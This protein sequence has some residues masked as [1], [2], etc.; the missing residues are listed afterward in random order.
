MRHPHA[1][2]CVEPGDRFQSDTRRI[3]KALEVLEIDEDECG[4]QKGAPWQA[5]SLLRCR[6]FGNLQR[7]QSCWV[8]PALASSEPCFFFLKFVM[9]LVLELEGGRV[10]AGLCCLSS[11]GCLLAK[12]DGPTF[13]KHCICW[14]LWWWPGPRHKPAAG[15]WDEI[16]HPTQQGS[17]QPAS[18]QL[19]SW[20][21]GLNNVFC[22]L[23]IYP[24]S[25]YFFSVLLLF[26][27]FCFASF[28]KDE[29][30]DCR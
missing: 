24:K 11:S 2:A 27:F 6:W 18:E 23:Q 8:C 4:E 20:K 14:D 5:L 15:E 3:P 21:L 10:P 9:C 17:L 13:A 19:N 16:I 30:C 25:I 1:C 28:C 22:Q 26:F 7:A 12:H 29:P